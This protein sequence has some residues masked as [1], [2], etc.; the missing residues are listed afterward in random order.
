MFLNFIE[1]SSDVNLVFVIQILG[2]VFSD[3]LM[4]LFVCLIF[5]VV[6]II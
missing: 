4:I 1:V 6:V 2:V 5:K 3:E